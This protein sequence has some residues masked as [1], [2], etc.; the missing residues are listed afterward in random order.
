M[1]SIK[2][3]PARPGASIAT[4]AAKARSAIQDLQAKLSEA[5]HGAGGAPAAGKDTA[6]VESE[7]ELE[8]Q[9]EAYFARASR[10][11]R[12]GPGAASRT[13][14]LDELRSRVIDGVVDRILEEWAS[15][16]SGTGGAAGLGDEVME[17]LIQRVL[18]QIKTMPERS[19]AAVGA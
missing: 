1:A 16:H 19:K 5:S 9:L 18:Q 10:S 4:A 13:A 17:R 14:I 8:R 7:E 3:Q 6:S 11:T 2:N 15:G 12:A